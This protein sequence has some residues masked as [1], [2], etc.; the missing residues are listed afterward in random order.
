[1]RGMSGLTW[2]LPVSS[3]GFFL[4]TGTA[5]VLAITT[6]I[7]GWLL[8]AVALPGIP[9]VWLGLMLSLLDVQ[10][11]PKDQMQDDVRMI[12]AAVLCILN[13][14]AFIPYWWIVVR[15]NPPIP[16]DAPIDGR[17]SSTSKT[18]ASDQATPEHATDS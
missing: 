13:V 5:V 3:I 9:F 15:Q 18:E 16:E 10:R 17:K 14:F 7:S 4:F 8:A 12:W 2:L 6:D 1:M 11:R